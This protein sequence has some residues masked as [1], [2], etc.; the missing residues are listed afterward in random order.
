MYRQWTNKALVVSL[1]SLFVLVVFA[2]FT[3][4]AQDVSPL[5]TFGGSIQQGVWYEQWNQNGTM[6]CPN[7]RQRFVTSS[8]EAFNLSA[9]FSEETLSVA[10]SAS[11]QTVNLA[12]T[13][14]GNYVA[15][16]QNNLWVQLLEVTR[17]SPTQMTATSTFYAKD[18]TCT[19]I[20]QASWSF[21]GQQQP[22]PQPTQPPPPQPNVCTVRPL[23]LT[24]NKRLGPGTNY[25]IIGKLF[26]GNVATV[27]AAGF[28][29][30]G[31][32]WWMLTDNSW[33]SAAY[34]VAQ[35]PCPR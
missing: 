32:R 1:F 3:V 15:T 14:V 27:S 2:P 29:N 28:D 9:P 24:V 23:S 20:N 4:L 16:S 34:T 33:V 11:R 8:S 7:N 5:S 25:Q 26:P 21:T 19:L 22:P 30:Q 6:Y 12:R 35:G 17:F 31:A 13:S 18:G 10:Y